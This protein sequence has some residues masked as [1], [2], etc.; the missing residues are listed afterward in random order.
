M[1]EAFEFR[2]TFGFFPPAKYMIDFAD[3][4]IVGSVLSILE[5]RADTRH[6]VVESVT[7]EFQALGEPDKLLKK[8]TSLRS[9]QK[10]EA[11]AESHL[12][13]ACRVA[14]RCGFHPVQRYEYLWENEQSKAKTATA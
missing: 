14:V 12:Y 1:F 2:K 3:E 13:R 6:R 8:R 9:A 10:A 5:K 7:Q 4:K 11:E